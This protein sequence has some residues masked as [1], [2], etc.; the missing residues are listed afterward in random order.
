ML[1]KAYLCPSERIP[2]FY[3]PS[4]S[5]LAPNNSLEPILKPLDR[6]DLIDSV[7][8]TNFALTSSPLG[9]SL[10]RSCPI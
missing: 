10:P 9:Y 3:A 8:R 4:L 2:P 1:A 7:T 5:T 6:F